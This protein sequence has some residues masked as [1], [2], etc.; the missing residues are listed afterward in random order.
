VAPWWLRR[1]GLREGLP[2]DVIAAIDRVGA[3]LLP[4]AENEPT[5]AQLHAQGL[6]MIG[7]LVGLMVLRDMSLQDARDLAENSPLF[8]TG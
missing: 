2:T 7:C 4:D 8:L 1:P 6:G 5:L 3:S